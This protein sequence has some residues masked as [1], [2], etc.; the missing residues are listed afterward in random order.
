VVLA[1]VSETM[2]RESGHRFS[3]KDM[4]QIKKCGCQSKNADRILIFL[5]Q[6]AVWTSA[7]AHQPRRLLAA[8]AERIAN[9]TRTLDPPSAATAPRWAGSVEPLSQY[10]SG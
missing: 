8:A 1:H 4:R 6:D 10:R 2:S 7:R 3:D 5:N 9:V